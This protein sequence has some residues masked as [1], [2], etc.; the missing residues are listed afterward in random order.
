MKPCIIIPIY[1]HE[2]A[3][4]R[5]LASLKTHGIFCLLVNDGSSAACS[6]VLADCAMRES[7]WVV[8]LNLPQNGGKGTAVMAGFKEAM[9]R[10]FTHALQI[11]ADGQHD[12]DDIPKFLEAGRLHPRAMILGNP[13]FDETVPKARLYGRKFTNLWIHINTLSYAI[14]DG[15]CGFRLY[16]LAAVDALTAATPLAW[17]MD[18]DIDIVVRLYWRGVAFINIP[19]SVRYPYDGVSH[20]K[21]WRDNLMISKIHARLFFGMLVRIPQLLNRRDR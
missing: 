6:Q 9:R 21:Q 3:I 10:G 8:L 13:V 16:P 4:P 2:D 11:D 5:V 17:R 20:F 18:F 7:A 15:M 12:A 19:V 1:N 14:V